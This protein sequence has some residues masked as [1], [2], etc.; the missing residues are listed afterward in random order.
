MSEEPT[1]VTN[2]PDAPPE[3][4]SP[5][6]LDK[7]KHPGNHDYTWG[8]GRRKSAIA[9]VRIRPGDGKFMVNKRDM[10]KYFLLD[11]DRLAVRRP[12]QVTDT[13][14]SIDI[15]VNVG[16]GGTSGQAGAVLLGIARALEKAD[17][18]HKPKLREQHLLKRDPRKVERK[19]YG[20]RGARRRFQF[21]KR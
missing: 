8:T 13:A 15:F 5:D 3:P 7:K 19:K 20:Q 14:K 18:D 1:P 16:G 11:K 9:R 6:K 21:S 17:L 4:S 2:P 10:E 12:L